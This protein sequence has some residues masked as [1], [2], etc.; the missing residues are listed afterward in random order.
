MTAVP[1]DS[2][3]DGGQ[4]TITQPQRRGLFVQVAHPPH[5]REALRPRQIRTELSEHAAAGRYRGEPVGVADEHGLDPGACSRGEELAQIV[6]AHHA[7][8][9]DDHHGA[10]IQSQRFVTQRFEGLATV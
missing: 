3:P 9:V 4:P 5:F 2:P 7:R 8:L 6:G 1:L 10:P